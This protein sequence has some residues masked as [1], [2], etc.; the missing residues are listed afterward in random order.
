MTE[1]AQ[2]MRWYAIPEPHVSQ[3]Q[4]FFRKANISWDVANPYMSILMGLKRIPVPEGANE[5]FGDLDLE[6]KPAKLAKKKKVA[7][8]T[9]R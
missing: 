9:R 5:V 3:L 4:Q 7:K 2:E 8:K 1:Q 6:K